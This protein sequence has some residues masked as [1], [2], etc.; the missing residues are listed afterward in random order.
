MTRITCF[1]TILAVSAGMNAQ[2][3]PP[4]GQPGTTAIHRDSS[5]IKAWA[6]AC[7]VTRGLQD[8][9]DPQ[10]GP[11]SAGTAQNAAGKS[12]GTTVSLGDG[13]VAICTFSKPITNGPGPDFVVFEN[14]VTDT[15]L[16]LGFVDV[17]SD[18]V[19]FVRFK[20][21]SLSDTVTQTG[22]FDATDATKLNNFAGKY[23]AGFGTPFDL[24]ELAS[25]ATI[26]TNAITH[27]RITDVV[28]GLGAQYCSRD[29]FGNKVNDPWP[30][31]FPSSGFD[32]DAVGVINAAEVTGDFREQSLLRS[33]LTKNPVSA[34]EEAC[35][36][37]E[38][39][40][41]E[42]HNASGELVSMER[43]R[44]ISTTALSPGLY[45]LLIRRASS[46]VYAKLLVL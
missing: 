38:A 44:C 23:R 43:G 15:F 18:G 29:G 20:S 36:T 19:N 17:S 45:T 14:G 46:H 5:A 10:L 25:A 39:L 6:A 32:L 37:G 22:G 12:D 42:C 9:S 24:Q 3:A 40:S 26:N 31:P 1:I 41:I 30:T 13:G 4:A 33:I 7:T 2:Y 16:E 28:G 35:V 34:G 8:A 27:V 11:A 21:H